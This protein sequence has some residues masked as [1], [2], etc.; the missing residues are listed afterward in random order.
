MHISALANE[1][2]KDPHAVVSAGDI[3]KVK[4]ME[5]DSVRKRIAMSMRLSDEPGQEKSAPHNNA[6]RRKPD[7]K[8]SQV[9]QSGKTG[10]MGSLLAEALK[11]KK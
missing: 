4:I 2:V 6:S 7:G 5:V 3:V 10:T 8:Q 1:F 9:A 11:A